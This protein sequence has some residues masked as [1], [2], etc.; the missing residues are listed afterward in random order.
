M[1][2]MVKPW[3]Y[4]AR[5]TRSV[6]WTPPPSKL[7]REPDDPYGLELRALSQATG[8]PLQQC[9][10]CYQRMG[11]F[12]DSFQGF[13]DR[14]ATRANPCNFIEA[15]YNAFLARCGVKKKMVSRRMFH[16]FS[17]TEGF[18]RKKRHLLSFKDAVFGLCALGVGTRKAQA[19]ALFKVMDASG[20]GSVTRA[21]L[22]AFMTVMLPDGLEL[23][24]IETF[25]RVSEIFGH[26]DADGGGE[27]DRDEFIRGC[28]E[29]DEVYDRIQTM[30]PFKRY[31]YKWNSKDT[32][33]NNIFTALDAPVYVSENDPIVK[34]LKMLTKRCRNVY[35]RIKEIPS[36]DELHPDLQT[37]FITK[38]AALDVLLEIGVRAEWASQEI[39]TQKDRPDGTLEG[40]DFVKLL[41]GTAEMNPKGFEAL[42]ARFAAQDRRLEEE[43]SRGVGQGRVKVD[44]SLATVA[45]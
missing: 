15:E 41:V 8:F 20:D 28:V 5:P 10:E 21:E 32:S 7:L 3:E 23:P 17:R 1:L 9:Y 33:L 11:K 24:K 19:E 12:A 18:G 6:L 30:S 39:A 45:Y 29:N 26:L 27:L 2:S 22:L 13:R 4:T 42:E 16:A 43:R 35:D 44:V 40:E 25:K 36:E 38:K 37:P 34:M 31:F 14:E